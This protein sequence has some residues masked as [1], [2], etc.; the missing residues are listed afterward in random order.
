M[1]WWA[2]RTDSSAWVRLRQLSDPTR[3]SIFRSSL[4]EKLG[5]HP[6]QN[7][8]VHWLLIVNALHFAGLMSC[9]LTRRVVTPCNSA[10][11]L[12][13]LDALQSIPFGSEYN[14]AGLLMRRELSESFRNGH[15]IWWSH[16]GLYMDRS[17]EVESFDEV[18]DLIRA[19]CGKALSV[20]DTLCEVDDSHMHNLQRRPVRWVEHFRIQFG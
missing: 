13:L 15:D 9:D 11:C 3:V 12:R 8:N 1:F 7:I 6:T 17:A 5:L 16:R 14:E 18:F 10:E 2:R 19:T 20:G 4:I